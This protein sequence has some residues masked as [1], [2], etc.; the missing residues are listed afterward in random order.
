MTRDGIDAG[1]KISLLVERFGELELL[2]LV[3][4]RVEYGQHVRV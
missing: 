2:G 1:K 4:G 3:G